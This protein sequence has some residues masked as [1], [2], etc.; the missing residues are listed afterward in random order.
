MSRGPDAGALLVRALYR[1]SCC[2]GCPLE[3]IE[4]DWVRWA[5]VTFTGARHRMQWTG[6]ASPA[7]DAWLAALP[8]ADLPIRGHL[9]ADIT[10]AG[11]THRADSVKIEIEALTLEQ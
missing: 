9:L 4:A 3:I 5:S 8:R 1:D 11:L 10:V 6:H 2:A 7:L